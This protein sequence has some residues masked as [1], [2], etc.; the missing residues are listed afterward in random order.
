MNRLAL[1]RQMRETYCYASYLH[2]ELIVEGVDT[3]GKSRLVERANQ[4]AIASLDRLYVA[5][6]SGECSKR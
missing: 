4:F 5:V 2:S 1:E 3:L 6:L